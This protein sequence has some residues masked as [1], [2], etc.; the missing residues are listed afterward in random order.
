MASIVRVAYSLSGVMNSLGS[1]PFSGFSRRTAS[2]E[3]DGEYRAS[4]VTVADSTVTT[5]LT[6]ITSEDVALVVVIP[7]VAGR[8]GWRS[9]NSDADNSAVELRA[10]FP[11]FLPAGKVSTYNAD[12]EVAVDDAVTSDMLLHTIKFYQTT[13]SAAPVHILVFGA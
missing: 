12:P 11:F 1:E 10:N 7:T 5:L 8:L 2:L 4:T 9:A 13:G 6:S 3:F